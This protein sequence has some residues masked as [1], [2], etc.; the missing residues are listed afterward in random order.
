MIYPYKCS[1]CGATQDVWQKLSEYCAS[2]LIPDHCGVKMDRVFTVPMVAPDYA[3]F[4]SHLD[5]SVIN[6]RSAQREHMLRHNVVLY[7]EVASDLPA[8][9]AAVTAAHF[10]DLKDDINEVITMVEQG[11]KPRPDEAIVTAES[12]ADI[13][14]SGID[15]TSNLP[16]KEIV[17]T[18]E[19]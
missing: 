8:K 11:Y 16:Q 15:F 17:Q 2:P 7:D 5:G 18:L 9:R 10:A 12:V 14:E 19:L 4:I 3:P 13:S 1:G 6:S